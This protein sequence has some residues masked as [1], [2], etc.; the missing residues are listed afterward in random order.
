MFIYFLFPTHDWAFSDI[1]VTLKFAET[2]ANYTK[3]YDE[4]VWIVKKKTII[5]LFIYVIL[6]EKSLHTFYLAY[7][8]YMLQLR[9]NLKIVRIQG[10]RTYSLS[11]Q[12]VFC[13]FIA[14]G[15]RY[16][17]IN[18]RPNIF[19]TFPKFNEHSSSNSVDFE[20]NVLNRK[21]M[22]IFDEI[23]LIRKGT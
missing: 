13:F 6:L 14:V 10:Y 7:I 8:N 5:Y 3:M 18:M 22:D 2:S 12:F 17:L 4:Y 16:S 9:I 21:S 23:V 19:F 20:Q 1:T 15:K 11:I